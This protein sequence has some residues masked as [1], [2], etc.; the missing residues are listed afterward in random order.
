MPKPTKLRRA[1]ADDEDRTLDELV[2]IKKLVVLALVRSGTPQSQ[3]AIALGVNQSQ[4][5][6]LFPGGLGPSKAGQK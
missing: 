6:R 2:A 4:V 3:I 5:S 1:A